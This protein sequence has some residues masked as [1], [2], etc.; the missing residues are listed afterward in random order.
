MAWTRVPARARG[1]SALKPKFFATP[2]KFRAW[3]ERNH[4][5]AEEVLV[6]FYK[7]ATGKPSM[8]WSEAVDEAL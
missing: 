7:K 5:R 1:G 3:L 8:T 2:D 6:G 4:D